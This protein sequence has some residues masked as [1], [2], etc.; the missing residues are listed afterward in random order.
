M[1]IDGTN[2]RTEDLLVSGVEETKKPLSRIEAILRGE[3][4]KPQSRIE[5]ALKEGGSGGGGYDTQIDTL[6]SANDYQENITLA[7]PY[8]DYDMLVVEGTIALK[9]K[10]YKTSTTYVTASININDLIGSYSD[11]S[12]AWYKVIDTTNLSN[13]VRLDVYITNIYGIKYGSGG[14]GEQI[15]FINGRIKEEN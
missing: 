4:I 3:D 8:T 5:K 12:V 2:S 15:M 10:L 6:F 1:Q 14:G 7:H 13:E 9:N 11:G